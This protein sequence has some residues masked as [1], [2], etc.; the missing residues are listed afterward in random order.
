ML[1]SHQDCWWNLPVE[2]AFLEERG[3]SWHAQ[4][5]ISS[6]W[7]HLLCSSL[8]LSWSSYCQCSWSYFQTCFH[9]LSKTKWK[10]RYV[11][12]WFQNQRLYWFGGVT[13]LVMRI[14]LC[15]S[16]THC[17]TFVISVLVPWHSI[18]YC[19]LVAVDS[20]F[21]VSCLNWVSC[22]ILCHDYRVKTLS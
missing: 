12:D 20:H 17:C 4:Q 11:F 14:V 8:F 10:K 9:Q 2:K 6:G 19:A 16:Q 13:F 7:Y 22:A 5:L 15:M 1:E 18:P 3:N 21:C